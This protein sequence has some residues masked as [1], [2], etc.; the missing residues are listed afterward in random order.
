LFTK[1]GAV[2]LGASFDDPASNK[3][4]ADKHQFPFSLLSDVDRV[5]GTAYGVVRP[6]GHKWAAMPRRVTFLI[7]P[8]KVVRRVYDVA[9][10]VT[11]AET[12][13]TDLQELTSG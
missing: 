10:V 9:D 6:A 4:F 8:V 7:D 3:R 5:I 13:L 1:L 11:H 2:I 12:V